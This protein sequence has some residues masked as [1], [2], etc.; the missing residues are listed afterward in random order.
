VVGLAAAV[1]ALVVAGASCGSGAGALLASEMGN[2]GG[3]GTTAAIWSAM[4]D[5]LSHDAVVIGG[6]EVGMRGVWFWDSGV[7]A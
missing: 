5:L 4:R 6:R 1:V 7:G 3:A 2:A